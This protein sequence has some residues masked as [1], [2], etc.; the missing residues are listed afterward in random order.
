MSYLKSAYVVEKNQDIRGIPSI[1]FKPSNGDGLIPTIIHYH[2]WSSNKEKQRMRA[3]ILASL[4]Y[5][6]VLPDAIY[7]GERSPLENYDTENA[8]SY[9]WDTVFQ[10]LDESGSFIDELISKYKADP[11]RIGVMGHSMGGITGA[12][13][14]VHEPRIKALAVLNGT[15]AW[16]NFNEILKT[17]LES[18]KE[19]GYMEEVE[20]RIRK[21]D[22][23]N[24]LDKI[25]DRPMILLH[26][27]EDVVVPIKT[28]EYFYERVRRTY[29]DKRKIKI[30]KYLYLNHLIT[31]NMMEDAIGWFHKYL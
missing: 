31:T 8:I 22:P 1:I 2:G 5:Q 16:E 14:F 18:I 17:S 24:N 3:Y 20:E 23:I 11:A 26:G 27:V 19:L 7:H 28:Q 29:N 9:F 6:V 30:M 21:L 12:G 13:I 15:G 25:E 4:G 10:N